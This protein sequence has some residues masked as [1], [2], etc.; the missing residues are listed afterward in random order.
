[1]CTELIIHAQ[2][3]VKKCTMYKKL[4]KILLAF[5][6][7]SKNSKIMG[8]HTIFGTFEAK[9]KLA[10]VILL[11]KILMGNFHYMQFFQ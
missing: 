8:L 2:T 9:I 3:A 11:K 1:M 10:N 5:T 7:G 4:G 6:Y